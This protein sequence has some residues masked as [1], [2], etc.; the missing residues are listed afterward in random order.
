MKDNK[1]YHILDLIEEI[2][3]VDKMLALHKDSDSDLMSSQYKNQKLKLSNYLVKELLINS[4]NRTEVMYI[5]KLF[6]EKF[7]N[8]EMSH[9]QFEENDNL[10]KIENVFIENYA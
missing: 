2:D 5:I 3:K 8:N 1:L 4:D 7:Y 10:K 9:L 6:I